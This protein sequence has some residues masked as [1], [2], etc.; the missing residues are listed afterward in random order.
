[1]KYIIMC[2][3]YVCDWEKPKHLWKYKGKPI[4]CR[5]I[6][7]LQKYGVTDIAITTSPKCARRYKSFKVPVIKYEANNEPFMWVDA[8]YPT[9]EPVCYLFG[10]VVY[11]QKAIWTIVSTKTVDIEFFGSAPPFAKEYPKKHAEPFAFKVVNQKRFQRCVEETKQ[12]YARG[13][14]NRHPIAWE[15]WQ[16]IKGTQRNHI[17]Y[18]NYTVINDYT[19][20]V[21]WEGDLKQW[22]KKRSI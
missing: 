2:G 13:L 8:F 6:Q 4:V 7:L 9:D 22:K 17:I 15:L 19:C 1:M 10:D 11:S 16:V 3:G 14:W 21:D 12:L 20:D 18:D 5:T